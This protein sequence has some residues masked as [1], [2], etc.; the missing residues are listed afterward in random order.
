MIRLE[1]HNDAWKKSTEWCLRNADRGK[2]SF[3]CQTNGKIQF[4]GDWREFE[5]VWDE[6]LTK[7]VWREQ[8]GKW[9]KIRK[10]MNF[11]TFFLSETPIKIDLKWVSKWVQWDLPLKYI[12]FEDGCFLLRLYT[13]FTPQRI[14]RRTE[15]KIPPTRQINLPK[16]SH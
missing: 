6:I 16:C 15:R 3:Q 14:S 9:C 11:L 4:F 8:W 5:R 2:I 10:L 1:K 12:R 13:G 7:C